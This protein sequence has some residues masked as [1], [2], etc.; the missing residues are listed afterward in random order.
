MATNRIFSVFSGRT[1]PGQVLRKILIFTS[2]LPAVIFFNG[3]VGQIATINGESMYPYLNT[4]Y[5]ESLSRDKCW[6]NKLNPAGNL[7][8]GMLVTFRSP[9]NPEF[10]AVKRVIAIEGDRVFPRAPY[11]APVVD[12]PA[13]HVWVEG[14]NR[15]GK[16]TLDSNHYGPISA[17]LI[18]GKVTH[19]IWP[20]KSFGAVRWWEF[21]AR[22]RVIQGRRE[23]AF[24]FG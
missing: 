18:Q 11:P 9:S 23:N 22:T 16:K 13:G 7:N 3:N 5:N 8:R 12:I 21:K 6:V 15:D 24:H 1:Q 17:S 10:M 20:W 19:V 2:W 14:D 4:S